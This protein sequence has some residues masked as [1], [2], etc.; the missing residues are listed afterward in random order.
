VLTAPLPTGK[1]HILVIDDEEIIT[2]MLESILK[3]L[4][5]QVTISNSGPEALAL[6]EQKTDLF[7]VLITDMT[8]PHL[9]GLELA[10]KALAI[11]PDLPIILCTGFS[12]LINKEQA[13]SIGIRAYLMKPVSVREMALTVRQV[14]TKDEKTS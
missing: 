1:E 8:M 9:T 2:G 10:R 4:G 12:E 7:D 11:R 5:Y 3:G 13:R 6:L 14:L